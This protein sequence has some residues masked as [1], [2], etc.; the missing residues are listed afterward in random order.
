MKHFK[1]ML[2]VILMIILALWGIWLMAP[3]V[4]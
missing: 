2:A 3:G 1:L 4:G